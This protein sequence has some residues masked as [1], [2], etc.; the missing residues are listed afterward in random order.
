MRSAATASGTGA[1]T[2]SMP[3]SSPVTCGLPTR[4]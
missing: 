2:S 4:R 3:T 1:C